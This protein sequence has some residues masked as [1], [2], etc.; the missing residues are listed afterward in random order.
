MFHNNKCNCKQQKSGDELLINK[1]EIVI[2]DKF[3][4]EGYMKITQEVF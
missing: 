2:A 3:I 1:L 4:T